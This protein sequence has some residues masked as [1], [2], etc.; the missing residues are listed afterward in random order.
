[1]SSPP[2]TKRP[3]TTDHR[4]PTRIEDGGWRIALSINPRSDPRSSIL[5]PQGTTDDRRP[6]RIEDG[7]WRIALSIHPRSDPR[8]SILHPQGGR[9]SVV[10]GRWSV[11]GMAWL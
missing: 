3:P 11:V 10:G 9:W 2:S 8:S 6:T 5:H 1:M 4:R 7:G